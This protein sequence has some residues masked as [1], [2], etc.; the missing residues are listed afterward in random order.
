MMPS[1]TQPFLRFKPQVPHYAEPLSLSVSHLGKS[2]KS[3]G[4]SMKCLVSV[5]VICALLLGACAAPSSTAEPKRIGVR[6]YL[7]NMELSS[8]VALRPGQTT[9]IELLNSGMS[10]QVTYIETRR[11]SHV[12]NF[13]FLGQTE[14]VEEILHEAKTTLKDSSRPTVAYL[15][16]GEE[17]VFMSP[18]PQ[19][20]GP[21]R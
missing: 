5:V 8:T 19:A 16:C 20:L 9:E 11:S 10:I 2:V 4:R 12:L 18:S 1:S 21:C 15:V 17:V 13:R 7:G 3:Q 14:Y 6:T